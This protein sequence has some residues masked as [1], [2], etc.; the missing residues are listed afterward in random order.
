MM[1]VGSNFLFGRPH[2]ACP[3]PRPNASIWIVIVNSWLLERPQKRSHRNQ[4]IHRRLK[5]NR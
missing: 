3:P 2:G 5:Q 1:S 4:L